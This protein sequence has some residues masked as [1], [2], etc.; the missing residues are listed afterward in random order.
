MGVSFLKSFRNIFRLQRRQAGVIVD[1]GTDFLKVLQSFKSSDGA[2][3]HV[4][5]IKAI[6]EIS[7]PLYDAIPK[8]LRE[9]T[10]K[11]KHVTTYLP[12]GMVNL[13]Q[14][15]IP[16]TD[17]KE[18]DDIVKMQAIKQTPY[19]RDEV[20]ISYTVVRTRKEEGYSDVVIAFSQRKFV[21]ERLETLERSG[22]SVDRIGVS[23][24][25]VVGWYVRHENNLRLGISPGVVMIVDADVSST[26]AVFCK[27]GEFVFSRGFSF[28]LAEPS[29][30]EV[31]VKYC[32]ELKRV[33]KLTMDEAG[34]DHPVKAVLTGPVGKLSYLREKIEEALEIPVEL[35]NPADDMNLEGD[36]GEVTSSVSALIGFSASGANSLFDLT[37]EDA[38]LRRHVQERG[39]QLMYTGGLALALIA[40]I[41][42]FV[43]GDFYKRARYLAELEE[44]IGKTSDAASDV[45]G[46]VKR[47]KLIQNRMNAD[48]SFLKY[49]KDI[50]ESIGPSIHFD[51][52]DYIDG[53]KIVLKGYAVE[54]SEVF[55]YT[56]ALENLKLFKNVKSEQ[57]SK[58][59]VG[60]K[61]MSEFEIVCGL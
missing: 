61:N 48:R 50:Y 5:R 44:S 31:A 42:L 12:R 59:K 51:S 18:I 58:K 2:E 34:L 52:L 10:L 11:N 3:E 30:P 1:I 36:M 20:A 53:D 38:K 33:V 21:D 17:P 60:D 41:F 45:D 19:S 14:I 28:L 23:S 26:D 54:M 39:R 47:L 6:A 56:K 55:E 37:P 27:N 25:G 9:F 32:A 13:R 24:E 46:K 35:I 22:L 43:G 49:F 40:A 7:E 16:S 4:F 15:E 57:V 8:L 29:L